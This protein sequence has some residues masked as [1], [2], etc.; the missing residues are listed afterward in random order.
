MAESNYTN[1]DVILPQNGYQLPLHP[2]Q[3]AVLEHKPFY[4]AEFQG[5]TDLKKQSELSR[6]EREWKAR[7]NVLKRHTNRFCDSDL[8][9]KEQATDY[10]RWKYQNFVKSHTLRFIAASIRSFLSFVSSTGI[11]SLSELT[12]KDIELYV[13]QEL[14]RGMKVGSL[15][16]RLG[17]LNAFLHFL[18]GQNLLDPSV[19]V[20]RIKLQLPTP[21]PRA[22]AS[23]DVS[24]LLAAIDDVRDRAMILILLR[25]GM[26][27]GEMLE[28]R[29][30]DINF[31]KQSIMIYTGEK[32]DEGRLV[33]FTEDANMAILDWLEV[34]NRS[35]IYLFYG[36]KGNP[37]SY[38][39]AW[40]CFSNCLKKA[41]LADKG[42]TPHC[43]RHTFATDT[44]N[45]RLPIEVL[46][47]LL[48]HSNIEMTSRY[49]RLTDKT[50]EEEYFKAMRKLETAGGDD[51]EHQRISN[52][53][54][55]VFEKKKLFAA[56]D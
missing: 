10:L 22:I 27:I 41:G 40:R 24:A 37:L 53:L 28:L 8:P 29:V 34:R 38:V 52:R 16:S 7:Q 25:T 21:L 26:R 48:G 3:L 46:Q 54:Q 5:E 20:H 36:F 18:V 15:H 39:A 31:E 51:H 43:L 23:V 33:Y 2:L 13:E 9:G 6:E 1:K 30:H 32:N 42:Y 45:A 56:H 55:A 35:E 49:A 14:S 4:S 11:K 17:C 19:I 12:R 47:E 44:L 50:R